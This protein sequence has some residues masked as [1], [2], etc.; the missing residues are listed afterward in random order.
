MISGLHRTLIFDAIDEISHLT[1]L[2]QVTA[3]LSCAAEKFGFTSWG[4]T[5][6]TPL[7]EGAYPIVLTEKIP[8]GFSDFYIQER[9]YGIDHIGAHA[10]AAYEPVPIQGCAL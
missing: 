6:L 5:G 1:L 3:T 9:F 8:E 7:A 2:S 10:R 4:I